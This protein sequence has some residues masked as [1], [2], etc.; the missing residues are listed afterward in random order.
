MGE[1]VAELKTPDGE[2]TLGWC[3]YQSTSEALFWPIFH[4]EVEAVLFSRAL[5]QTYPEWSDE[6][7]DKLWTRI[8]AYLRTVMKDSEWPNWTWT[9]ETETQIFNGWTHWNYERLQCEPNPK[10]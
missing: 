10:S 9:D 3:V 1:R 6:Q 7:I 5:R 2:H 8:R 4:S